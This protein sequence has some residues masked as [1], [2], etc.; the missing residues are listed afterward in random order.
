MGHGINSGGAPGIG[1]GISSETDESPPG[2][3]PDG[4]SGQSAF[5]SFIIWVSFPDDGFNTCLGPDSVPV[6]VYPAPITQG[7]PFT[8]PAV[9]RHDTGVNDRF[10][11]GGLDRRGAVIVPGVLLA[12]GQSRSS[13]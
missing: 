13:S 12:V 2:D 3:G 6:P 11:S 4:F 5:C 1:I 8:V 10:P 7:N 9:R